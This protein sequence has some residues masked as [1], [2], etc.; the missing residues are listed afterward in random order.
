MKFPF[1][2]PSY[3][4]ASTN[5]DSQRSLNLYPARSEVGTSKDT[6]LMCPTPGR[7]LFSTIPTQSIRGMWA[8]VDRAFVVSYNMLYE[9]FADSTINALG[10]LLTFSGPVSMSD[11]GLQ[12]IIVDGTPTGGWIFD[13]VANT[14]VQ[15]TAMG[16]TGGT[17]V[18][19]IDGYF[20]LNVPDT[21]IYQWS[22]LYDGTAWD[23]TDFANAEGSPDNLIA[24][25]TTH[26]QVFLIGGSTIEVIYNSGSSPDPFDRV[27][28]VFIQYGTAAPFSVQ[29]TANTVFWLG[30]DQSGANVVWMAAGYQP[31]RIS[32]T[33]IENYLSQYDTTTATSYTYQESGH[34][35]YVLN[36]ISAPSSLVY[37]I[38]EKQ[39]HERTRWNTNS[40]LYER[41]RAQFH[42][43]AFGKH[44]VSDYED[45]RI[46]E[47][48]LN[49]NDDAGT[50]IKRV[51]RLSYFTDDLEYL[52][53]SEFQLDMQTGIGLITD[54]DTANTDPQLFLRWSDD[55][56]HTWSTELSLSVGKIGQYMARARAMRLGRSRSRV[57]EVSIVAN[58]PVYLIAAHLKASQGY[59]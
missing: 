26:R 24:V 23:A 43:Y 52:Y 45:G 35:F 6:L 8:T 2:G 58:V 38:T 40:G 21:G 13:L 20:L 29:E 42:M 15:I 27:Q 28:G 56:A 54:A 14:Y 48:S 4:Y 34:Y 57:F 41:D 37:D 51:R 46:Y 50:L 36:I 30:Q 18:T 49:Y 11:N 22:A 47:Q 16:F 17:T 59:A 55:G 25:V 33:P 3:V 1:V 10:A 31:E 9:L 12:L 39:W 53:F 19:F 32:T 44:L 7:V 5:F